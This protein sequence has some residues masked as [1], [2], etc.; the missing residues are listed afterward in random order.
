IGAQP[1]K[2]IL[3]LIDAYADMKISGRKGRAPSNEDL[4]VSA[5][6]V[7]NLD[8]D[9]FNREAAIARVKTLPMKLSA[10]IVGQQDAKEALFRQATI[11]LA[12]V[13]DPHRPRLSAVLAGPKGTGKT[14]LAFTYGNAM[15]VP[16]KR[17]MLSSYDEHDGVNALLRDIKAAVQANAFTNFLL[18]EADKAKPKVL[19]AL[20]PMLDK[21][22]FT[23]P[24]HQV[25]GEWIDAA[26]VSVL[27]ASFIF[28]GNFAKNFS[29]KKSSPGF[30]S[31]ST[32]ELPSEGELRATIVGEGFL[33][34]LL[35]RV[36][37]V[38][39]VNYLDKREFRDVLAMHI[40]KMLAE[41]SQRQKMQIES[42]DK[43]ALIDALNEKYWAPE[44]S[45]R[46]ALRLLNKELRLRI[47][48]AVLSGPAKP[49]ALDLKYDAAKGSIDACETIIGGKKGA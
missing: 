41:Q 8:P 28:A 21:G 26:D 46:D 15:G 22:R 33:E 30:T 42:Q 35:D 6:R 17:L 20:I 34:E 40:E 14:E 38:S 44:M 43:D 4:K 32:Q 13:H 49:K 5:R 10:S 29:K 19:E 27:N 16:T 36:D 11:S 7:Y 31:V 2:M 45:N 37:S 9:Y 25:R 3:L 12:G 24:S 18:D 48:E 47:A 39:F 1:R 23:L